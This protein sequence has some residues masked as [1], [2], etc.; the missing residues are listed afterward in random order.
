MKIYLLDDPRDYQFA[1]FSHV[2]TWT[3]GEICR[4]CGQGTSRLIEPLLIEWEPDSDVIGDFSWCGYT[5]VI[6]QKV[7]KYMT[8]K[9]WECDFG[10]VEVVSTGNKIPKNKKKVPF[11]YTGDELS[12][13]MPKE[14]I[15]LNEEN[16]SVK[17][18]I[19]CPACKQKKY[20][21]RRAGIQIDKENWDG[22]NMF[23]IEQYGKSSA[24]FLTEKALEECRSAGFTNLRYIE[25][26]IIK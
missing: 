23:R 22:S 13:V 8:T 26:G 1:R 11:P 19:D 3:K 20:T 14:Y 9:A 21:F 15:R 6:S 12:W 7:K 4:T 25:A 10:A 18:E 5:M 24:T 17:L 2:G 16:S